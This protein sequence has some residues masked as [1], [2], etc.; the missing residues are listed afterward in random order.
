M[1]QLQNCLRRNIIAFLFDQ[2]AGGAKDRRFG[3]IF[4]NFGQVIEFISVN[5][6]DSLIFIIFVGSNLRKQPDK[7]FF[8]V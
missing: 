1:N 4:D 6:R 3:Y 7:F 5:Q 8:V 2:T